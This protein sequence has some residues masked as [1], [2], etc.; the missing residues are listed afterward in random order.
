VFVNLEELKT[1]SDI[2][3]AVGVSLR[4]LLR[5]SVVDDIDGTDDYVQFGT[6]LINT[7]SFTVALFFQHTNPVSGL[8]E[9]VS[10]G[11]GFFLGRQNTG[12][13]RVGGANWSTSMPVVGA[14]LALKRPPLC[15]PPIPISITSL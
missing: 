9:L 3:F 15:T 5:L 10:Q 7:T 11:T 6:E 1:V 14:P 2:C 8:R 13:F 12:K 4:P